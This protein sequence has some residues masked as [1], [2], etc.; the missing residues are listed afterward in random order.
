MKIQQCTVWLLAAGLVAFAAAPASSAPLIL[1]EDDFN[2]NS[3]DPAKWN[4]VLSGIPQNPKSV[5]ETGGQMRLEGRGHLNTAQ[6]F[7]P[8][9]PGVGGLKITGTWE[10]GNDDFLQILTRSDG[11]PGGGYGETNNGIEMFAFTGNNQVLIRGR[12]GASVTGGGAVNLP[13]GIPNGGI[14]DFEFTDDGTNLSATLT[15][16]GNPANTATVTATSTSDMPTDLIVFHNRES[17]RVAYLDDVVVESLTLLAGPVLTWDGVANGN[18]SDPRWVT[19]PPTFPDAT[20]DANIG[21]L[22]TNNTVTVDGDHAARNLTI[23]GNGAL[24]V[25]AG[26]SLDIGD[27]LQAAGRPVTLQN[28]STLTVGGGGAI[29]S[30]ATQGNATLENGGD[31]ASSHLVMQSGDTFTKGGAGKLSFDLSAGSNVIDGS[32]TV[33]V[34]GGE[35][36]M[37]AAS[38][39]IGG[40]DLILD[41][42]T[43][44]VDG[45]VMYMPGL[46]AG[47]LTG[48]PA[49]GANPGN[50]G[51]VLSLEGMYRDGGPNDAK[52]EAHWT[53]PRAD[54]GNGP[55]NTTLIYSGQINLGAVGDVNGV[56]TF[57]EQNDDVTRLTVDGQLIINDGSWNNAVSAQ[58]TPAGGPGWYDFEVRFS[59]GGGGY[60]FFGQQ[61]CGDSN[62]NLVDFGF[63]TAAGLVS[64]ENAL[65]YSNPVDPGDGSVF[66]TATV[67]P[68]DM[69]DTDVTVRSD[70]TLNAITNTTA[71][72]GRLTFENGV[73]TTQ[74]AP[75]GMSF[76]D[77]TIDLAATRVGFDTQTNTTPGAID[78]GNSSAT[79]V[80]TGPA[81]LV[82]D[83]QGVNLGNATFDV[84]EGRMKVEYASDPTGG[85]DIVLSGGTFTAQGEVVDQMRDGLSGSIF[86][87]IPRNE[88][89]L[90]LDGAN[91]QHSPTRV[92]TGDKPGTILTDAEDSNNN[93]LVT[94]STQNW[95]AFPNFNGNADDFVTAYSGRFTPDVSGTY[96]FHW[97]NDDRGLMYV[98]LNDDGQFQNSERVAAYAW[99]ANG[100]VNL[101]AGQGYNVIYMAQEYGG[102][103]NVWWAMT[104]PGGSEAIVN[105]SDGRGTWQTL[106]RTIDSVDIQNTIIVD[107]VTTPGLMETIFDG[108]VSNAR[109]N[110]EA[111]RTAAGSIG[112]SDGQGILASHLHYQDD[113]A[114]SARAAALGATG[115][116]NGNFAMLWVTDFT[117]DEAGAWGFRFN[118]V[119]DNAS[120]WVDTDQNGTFEIGD[121]FYDRGCCGG[122]GDQFTPSLSAGETYQFGIV[123]NDTGGG[124]YFRDMEFKSPS[125][126]WTNLDPSDPAQAGL[127][128]ITPIS[129]LELIT[130]LDANLRELV[131]K[132]GYLR[133]TGGNLLTVEQASVSTAT[134]G[135]VGLILDTP[136]VLTDV[137]G[138][139]GNGQTVEITKRGAADLIL[140]KQGTGLENATINVAEGRMVA[141][142]A[143][144]PLGEA[145]LKLSGGE[146]LLSSTGPDPAVF[147][148]DVQV[149]ADSTLTAG[150]GDA[151]VPGPITVQVGSAGKTV[152]IDA[153]KTLTMRSTDSYTLDVAGQLNGGNVAVTEGTVALSGGGTAANMTVSGGTASTPGVTITENLHLG[154]L[155]FEATAGSFDISGA[156]LANDAV[157]RTVTL[158]VSGSAVTINPA[159][160]LGAPGLNLYI[161]DGAANGIDYNAP[162]GDPLI[163]PVQN[164]FDDPLTQFQAVFN[165]ALATNNTAGQPGADLPDNGNFDINEPNPANWLFTSTDQHMIGIAGVMVISSPGDYSFGTASDDGS[166]LFIDL[167]Q[168]GTF[169]SGEMIVNNKG[170]HGRQERTGSVYLDAGVYGFAHAYYERGGGSNTEAKWAPGAG[171]SYGSQQFVNIDAGGPFYVSSGPGVIDLPNTH[172]D[173]SADATLDLATAAP[174]VLGDLTLANNANLNIT[175]GAPSV[176]FAGL[177]GE[178]TVAGP[179]VIL[180]EALAPGA[181]VGTLTVDTDLTLLDGVTYSWELDNTG[182]DLTNVTGDLALGDWTLEILDAGLMRTITPSEELVLFNY[183]TL[184]AGVGSWSIVDATGLGYRFSTAGA[185]IIDDAANSRVILTGILAVVPEPSTLL[186]WSLLAALGIGCGWRRRRK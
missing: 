133:V 137:T 79:I 151:G 118:S 69:T 63:G 9:D 30:V 124:G 66:R 81:D 18:W 42:G 132:N 180:R 148:N 168:D 172:V 31:I 177:S 114:V 176:S 7:D 128:S 112:S 175:G 106:V 87:G 162:V 146:A 169:E 107:N 1:L 116:D 164:F 33:R 121:R 135:K 8:L 74:G 117:P 141:Y 163:D 67:Q 62:W 129:T 75:G 152:S 127:W 2:D 173:A 39:P 22:G 149:T 45:A 92:L 122:S 150:Q 154:L 32:N 49:G 21:P 130:D 5:T 80:K 97:N 147:D 10:F 70:S 123:M 13:G 11:T 14:F 16:V 90:N 138:L 6:Q 55:N 26:N 108:T 44:T 156:D 99:N 51:T 24:I 167:D 95:G 105:P 48:N 54:G 115:F 65:N 171:V 17:G 102:G 153:G 73:L 52:R 158:G 68:I 155:S 41:G 160:S 15:Q 83:Q 20:A 88:S 174:A 100:N 143:S 64:G 113:A 93:V 120:L 38:N 58:F 185:Q 183:G 186:V 34:N 109:D 181:S 76:L 119:D 96:N 35:L 25:G 40:A 56:T 28:N 59:N 134:S 170:L 57:V 72:F 50:F 61:C 4:V 161:Q 71:A 110:I 98:D 53:G 85:A 111:F 136:T 29:G 131:L 184:S 37:Q 60:G 47:S 12:G 46:L 23:S 157:D 36:A 125:G 165:D 91:Y 82:L 144:N 103:Q 159:P 101:T 3:I 43:F 145:T 78:G 179:E 27:E 89:H 139:N 142:A 166:T 77:T 94:G 140:N 84:Q 19:P 182:N 104:E 86:R 126:G 178:G